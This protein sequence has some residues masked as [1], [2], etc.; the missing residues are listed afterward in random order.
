[1]L[2]NMSFNPEIKLHTKPHDTHLQI[3][4]D[5]LTEL[6]IAP[7]RLQSKYFCDLPGDSLL[8]TLS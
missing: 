1:M 8:L 4:E 6:L 7:K 5:L 3:Q 2:A